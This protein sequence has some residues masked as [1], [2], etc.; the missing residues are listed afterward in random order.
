MPPCALTPLPP[1]ASGRTRGRVSSLTSRGATPP[2]PAPLR[3]GPGH[4][5]LPLGPARAAVRSRDGLAPRRSG[6]GTVSSRYGPAPAA[7]R[8]R[9]RL[10]RCRALPLPSG[11]APGPRLVALLGLAALL[12]RE[13]WL[14]GRCFIHAGITGSGSRAAGAP[15]GGTGLIPQK[16]APEALLPGAAERCGGAVLNGASANDRSVLRQSPAAP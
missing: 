2:R 11:A 12:R 8:S 9:C 13:A 1:P 6:P 4:H 5:L 3:S 14:A 10:P 15:G 16:S 7:V